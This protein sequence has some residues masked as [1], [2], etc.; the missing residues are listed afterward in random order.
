MGR[1]ELIFSDNIQGMSNYSSKHFPHA[2]VDPPYGIKGDSHR[3]N[4]GRGRLAKSN[5]YANDLWDQLPPDDKYFEELFRV[6]ENQIIWGGN[7]FPQLGI[8]FKT[9]RRNEIEKFLSDNPIGW[10]A[11]DKLNGTTG[12]NDYELA[13]TS[14]DR[15]SFVYKYMWNGMMQGSGIYT[16]HLMQGKKELN[17]KRIHPAHKPV[18]LY[19]F[20]L[21][22]YKVKSCL[23]T[24]NGGGSLNIA[25]FDL[26]VDLVAFEK[27]D[28]YYQDALKRLSDH[29]IKCKQLESQLKLI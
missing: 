14:F 3:K 17:E 18:N 19:K 7:Y 12:F 28:I 24:H 4:K 26:G 6:S 2:I 15:P 20:L 11:W 1:I 16:G 8:P 27:V 5:D 25:C 23:D 9:P 13:W 21:L 29:K 10:I 22:E